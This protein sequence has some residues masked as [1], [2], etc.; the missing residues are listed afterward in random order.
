[1]ACLAPK[2]FFLGVGTGEALNEYSATGQWPEYQTR[3]EQM[4]EA[5]ELMRRCGAAR[6]SPT[7]EL[8][9][10]PVRQSSIPGPKESI[11]IYISSMVPNSAQF[12]RKYGDGLI[13]TGGEE[14]E[15]YEKIFANFK[16]GAKEAGKKPAQM[17][18]M[19]GACSRLYG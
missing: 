11:P 10:K 17:P 13:T 4:A 14:P 1:M 2:R 5:I 9:I 18:R 3:Q 6:K 19:G 15:I 16:A 7:V 12:A 8:I